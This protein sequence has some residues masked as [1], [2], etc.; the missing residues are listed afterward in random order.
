MESL[1]RGYVWC[2]DPGDLQRARVN[3]ATGEE[4]G[5]GVEDGEGVGSKVGEG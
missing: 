3:M 4:S 2:S 1:E 5:G